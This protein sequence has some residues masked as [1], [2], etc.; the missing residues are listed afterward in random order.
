MYIKSSYFETGTSSVLSFGKIKQTFRNLIENPSCKK[1]EIC[2]L[3][4]ATSRKHS[5][6]VK[7]MNVMA[8]NSYFSTE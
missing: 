8:Q 7:S 3:G 6:K 2:I 1:G 5:Q 4:N